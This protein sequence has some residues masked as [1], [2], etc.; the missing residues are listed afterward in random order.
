MEFK[1]L[2]FHRNAYT[3]DHFMVNV[4]LT[5]QEKERIFFFLSR[6]V[7]WIDDTTTNKYIHR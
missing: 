3:I 7:A 6:M 4:G 5:N 1:L 2:E